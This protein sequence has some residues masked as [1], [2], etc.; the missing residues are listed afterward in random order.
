M[1]LSL[2]YPYE[3][4]G[5]VFAI[6]Y[7]KLCDAGY[8]GLLFDIDNT[9][10]HHGDDPTPET[11]A[12]LREIEAIGLRPLMLSNND[13]ERIRRFLRN[14]PEIPFV[15]EADKPKKEGYYKA[16]ETLGLPKEQVLVIGDQVFT[17]VLGANRCGLGSILVKF[18]HPDP[19]VPIGKRRQA[20]RLVLKV[21]SLQKKYRHR[22]GDVLKA[23]AAPAPKKRRRQ[24]CELGPWAFKLAEQ[25][26]ILRRHAQDLLSKEKFAKTK[27]KTPLP[28]Q[29]AEHHS[30]LI[31]KGPGID[32]E[33]QY[34]KVTNIELAAARM[35]GTVIR[36]GETFSFWKLVGKITPRKGYKNGRVLVGSKIQPGIG[37]GLCNLVNTMHLLVLHSPLDV[38]EFHSHSDALAPDEG[39]K[40]VPF[41]AGTSISYNSVDYRFKNNTDQNIQLRLWVADE[42]LYGELRSEK[43]VPTR[44]EL[45]EEDHH[46]HKEGEKYYRISRIYRN[47]ID[48]QSGEILKKELVLDNHSEVMFDYGLIPK[49]Q[50]R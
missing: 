46:F 39:G 33:L 7:Q 15:S 27:Q 48:K 12:L 1:C 44:Y 19:A 36:P 29:V 50:I 26:E 40:R 38:T 43:E 47:V 4:A 11:D 3:Y 45:T 24:F 21:W 17:D 32:P 2:L 18:I 20:E 37:G 14:L 30:H 8:R 42:N 34:N 31:K 49:D 41:S 35:D 10:V 16:L 22:L 28:Q 6:D 9:L 13:D 25:K 5:S 23:D